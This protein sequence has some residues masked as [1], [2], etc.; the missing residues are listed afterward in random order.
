M[1]FLIPA[2]AGRPASLYSLLLL[3]RIDG[4]A[5]RLLMPQNDRPEGA[6]HVESGARRFQRRPWHR[7][8]LM[9]G[10]PFSWRRANR[11]PCRN[12][13]ASQL[14]Q[15]GRTVATLLEL[16]R[17]IATALFFAAAIAIGAGA[18]VAGR[19]QRLLPALHVALATFAVAMASFGYAIWRN[20]R[21]PSR[22]MFK[23]RATRR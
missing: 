7:D 8:G 9:R 1:T 17:E 22:R 10:R 12:I 13:A 21:R 23:R 15:G 2:H 18:L 20:H 14:H 16:P 19:T 11:L 4:N 6:H 5:C 3:N